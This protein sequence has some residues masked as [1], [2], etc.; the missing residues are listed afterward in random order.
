MKWLLEA[1]G[2]CNLLGMCSSCLV[3]NDLLAPL[4]GCEGSSTNCYET[5]LRVV[6]VET[7]RNNENLK[8]TS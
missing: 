4:F 1:I 2:L 5:A 7:E 6:R 8:L 3:V